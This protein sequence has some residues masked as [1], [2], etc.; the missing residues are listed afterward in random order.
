MLHTTIRIRGVSALLPVRYDSGVRTGRT[1]ARHHPV[2]PPSSSS[3]PNSHQPDSTD[4]DPDQSSPARTSLRLSL[5]AGDGLRDGRS[6]AA[7]LAEDAR[8]GAERVR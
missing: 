1:L 2:L 7:E 4:A 6:R 3:L 8:V 5:R